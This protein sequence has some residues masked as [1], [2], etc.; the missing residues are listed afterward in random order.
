MNMN[1]YVCTPI[2]ECKCKI[3]HYD[4]CESKNITDQEKGVNVHIALK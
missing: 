4:N 1:M 2:R 3:K